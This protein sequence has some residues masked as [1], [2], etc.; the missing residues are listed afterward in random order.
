MGVGRLFDPRRPQP[1]RIDSV[2]LRELGDGLARQ[3]PLS[4]P[5]NTSSKVAL[6]ERC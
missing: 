3:A 5:Q 4:G 2:Q 6:D 1:I